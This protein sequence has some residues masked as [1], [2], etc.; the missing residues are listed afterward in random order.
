MSTKSGLTLVSSS[1]CFGGQQNVYSHESQQLKCKMNFSVYIPPKAEDGVKVPLMYW[2]SG[3]TCTEQNFIIKSGFQKYAAKYGLLVVNPDTSPRGLNIE[4]EDTD[5]DFGTGAGFY[6]DATQDKWKNNYRM[7]SYVTQELPQIIEENFPVLKDCQ[8]IT[9]HSMGGHG[10]L[11]C[12]LKNP[13]LY[14]AVTAFAPIA[15][16]S[17]GKWGVKAFTGYLGSNQKDW[18]EWD[19]T[20]LVQKY[21][22]PPL[23]III[24]QVLNFFSLVLVFLNFDFDYNLENYF[25]LRDRL[26]LI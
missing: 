17:K 10:A 7:F 8:S 26:I 16:P 1:K 6:V 12:A 5:W 15:N 25:N 11:V 22:G 3:L 9:G 24:D 2:L 14:K 19:S 13:G 18:E 23:H 20:Y 4:G 21:N